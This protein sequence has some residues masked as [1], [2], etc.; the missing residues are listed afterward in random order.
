MLEVERSLRTGVPLGSKPLSGPDAQVPLFT[1]KAPAG[2][3]VDEDDGA[4]D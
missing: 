4:H 2:E 3:V 1:R